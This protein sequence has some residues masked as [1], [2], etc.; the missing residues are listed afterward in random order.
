MIN[1]Y[2]ADY[3]IINE[4]RP[5]SEEFNLAI[6]REL[7]RQPIARPRQVSEKTI[8]KRRKAAKVARKQRKRN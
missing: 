7:M 8:D 4:N 6:D 1:G 3:I 5:A 2:D